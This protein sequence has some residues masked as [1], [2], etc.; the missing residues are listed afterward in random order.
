MVSEKSPTSGQVR[1]APAPG[2]TQAQPS[3]PADKP[4]YKLTVY[5]KLTQ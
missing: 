5:T 3:G 4:V 1:A 2:R